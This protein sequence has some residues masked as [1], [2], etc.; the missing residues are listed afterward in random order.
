MSAI[1]EEKE[2]MDIMPGKNKDKIKVLS[3]GGVLGWFF[4]IFF[5]LGGVAFVILGDLLSGICY[6]TIALIIF[7]P[8]N[9][10]VEEGYKFRLSGWLK[11]ILVLGLLFIIG[12]Y[13]SLANRP[14]VEQFNQNVAQAVQAQSTS[15]TIPDVP[16]E[17]ETTPVAQAPTNQ[18]QMSYQSVF[19]FSGEGTK[20][21]EPFTIQGDRFKISYDC[22]GDFCQAWLYKVNG[23]MPEPFMNVG[24]S[25]KDETIM[26]GGAG[27]YYIQTNTMGRFT[28]T[29]Y[30]YK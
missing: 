28:M 11:I 15:V 30:D 20:S 27:Q 9:R 24:H 3:V 13:G 1:I 17:E 21:S 18:N 14:T 23:L 7:P 4:G 6:I 25:I 10:L 2:E 29:V 26:Y 22:E 12:K 8:F 16:S 5:F 19:T